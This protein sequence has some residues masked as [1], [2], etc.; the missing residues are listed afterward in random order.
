M[1]IDIETLLP[2]TVHDVEVRLAGPDDAD[3]M[4]RLGAGLNAHQGDPTDHLT[5]EVIARDLCGELAE[6]V[7]LIARVGDSDVG[8]ALYHTSYDTGFGVPG[9]YVAD[10]YVDKDYRGNNVGR[11]LMAVIVHSAKRSGRRYLWWASKLWNKPAQK[12]YAAW[13]AS[14]ETVMAHALFGEAFDR[15]DADIEKL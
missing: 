5:A 6:Y 15:F 11:A 13:G 3:V 12:V 7:T 1:P 10:L 8:Y 14:S 4:E 2:L 9:Y